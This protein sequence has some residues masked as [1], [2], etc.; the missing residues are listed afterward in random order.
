MSWEGTVDDFV[1]GM[2]R[3]CGIYG[4]NPLLGRLWG[5]LFLSAGP[6]ALDE[7]AERVGAAKST[8]SVAIRKLGDLGVV[9]RHWN[10]G[11]RRDF[12]EALADPGD[13]LREMVDRY[14]KPELAVWN[15]VN[16][17]VLASLRDAPDAPEQR[18]LLVRRVV[19][20]QAFIA[21]FERNLGGVEREIGAPARR[22]AVEFKP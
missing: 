10:R 2:A 1:E 11:D 9:R 6:M 3:I 18:D 15:Q 22:I 17:S 4:V 14:V 20:M 8:V 16:A 7:L 19:E 13:I 5:V 21:V 12:Y